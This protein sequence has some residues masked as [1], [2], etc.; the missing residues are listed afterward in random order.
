MIKEVA[1]IPLTT[2]EEPIQEALEAYTVLTDGS[3]T[4]EGA[5][6]SG[7][8]E[9][10]SDGRY[11]AATKRTVRYLG[12]K[13]TD[14]YIL[15]FA[16]YD[17][18]GSEQTYK[19]DNLHIDTDIYPMEPKIAP[20]SKDGVHTEAH[21]TIASFLVDSSNS[22]PLLYA[23]NLDVL[24]FENDNK[25]DDRGRKNVVAKIGEVGTAFE[26]VEPAAPRSTTTVGYYD[27]GRRW[28][29]GGAE[30]ARFGDP[31]TIYNPYED[32]VQVRAF[33]AID[34]LIVDNLHDSRILNN[35][36][37]IL[38]RLRTIEQV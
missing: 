32:V 8:L 29:G 22:D 35:E 38:R 15:A 13:V 21:L 3:V 19:L 27:Y 6:D 2:L 31:H 20:R 17:G 36:L 10:K 12:S 30:V 34:D 1:G 16:P 28:S 14:L 25:R 9:L 5:D 18:T 7:H 23:G 4:F 24:G 26:G 33:L 37:D 11:S